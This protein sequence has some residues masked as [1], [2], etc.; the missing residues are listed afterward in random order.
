MARVA[1]GPLLFLPL[2]L[3]AWTSGCVSGQRRAGEHRELI[4]SGMTQQE[5]ERTLGHSSTRTKLDPALAGGATEVWS[6]TYRTEPNTAMKVVLGVLVIAV[7]AAA[8]A[9]GGNVGGGGGGSGAEL[10]EFKVYFDT[11]GR[12]S[13]ISDVRPASNR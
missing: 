11:A 9:G 13:G 3:L 10:W 1:R 5:V 6:Y 2:C 4:R 8:V 7:V 12:V